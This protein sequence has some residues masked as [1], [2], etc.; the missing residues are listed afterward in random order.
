MISQAQQHQKIQTYFQMWLNRDWSRLADL[1][2]SN[3]VYEE[4]YG[5]VY[6][7][8]AEIQQWINHQK[9]KQVVTA[10]PIHEFIDAGPTV[11]VTWTFAAREQ[12]S[13]LFDGVSIIHFA[14]DG[15]F[16]QVREFE[17]KHERRYPYENA[18]TKK[19]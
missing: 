11:I 1:F 10:W 12:T 17:A 5:P 7:N 6:R 2:T 14:A 8:F 13:Y 4:C 16:D 3:C 18:E 19:Y 9:Q 15:R